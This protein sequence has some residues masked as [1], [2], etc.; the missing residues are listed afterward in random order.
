[1]PEVAVYCSADRELTM[2]FLAFLKANL[3]SYELASRDDEIYISKPDAD[4]KNNTG[5][6]C[7][8]IIRQLAESYLATNHA[9]YANYTI[10]ETKDTIAIGMPLDS[11]RM[12]NEGMYFE[13]S[14]RRMIY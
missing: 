9:K 1:M 5:P 6:N 8:Q 7:K 13:R 11:K 14:F 4:S 2:S 10:T 3:A 12:E